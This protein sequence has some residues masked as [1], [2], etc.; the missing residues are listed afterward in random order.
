[1]IARLFCWLGFH[2]WLCYARWQGKVNE[3]MP[4]EHYGGSAQFACSR[5]PETR[6]EEWPR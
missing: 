6:I 2:D 3:G 4:G 5:C 1:M